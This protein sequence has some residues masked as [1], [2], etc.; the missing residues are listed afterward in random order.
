MPENLNENDK[1]GL[2]FINCLYTSVKLFHIK[3]IKSFYIKPVNLLSQKIFSLLLFS[4]E[5]GGAGPPVERKNK[6]IIIA[7]TFFFSASFL[8]A[9]SFNGFPIRCFLIF[10]YASAILLLL[11]FCHNSCFHAYLYIQYNPHIP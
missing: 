1:K 3:S 8:P 11:T 5:K 6:F 10:N 4:D 9:S 2:R 7:C